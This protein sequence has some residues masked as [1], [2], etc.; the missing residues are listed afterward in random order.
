MKCNACGSEP[1]INC[2]WNQGRCPN[3]PPA[4]EQITIDSIKIKCYNIIQ[5]I[6]SWFK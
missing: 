3:R 5:S 2:D 1:K 6:K 4:I